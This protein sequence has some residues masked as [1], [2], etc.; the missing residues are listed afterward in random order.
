MARCESLAEKIGTVRPSLRIAL[1]ASFAAL[2]IVL[3]LISPFIPAIGIPDIKIRLEASFASLFGFVLGPYLGASAALIGTLGAT[4]LHGATLFDLIFVFNPA[5]NALIVGLVLRKQWKV[6]FAMFALTI[7]AFWLTP[8]CAPLSEYWSVGLGANF[9]KILALLLIIP[10]SRIMQQGRKD[11]SRLGV[12][13]SLSFLLIFLLSFVGNQ[14]DAALGNNIF[15]LP[16]VYEGLFSLSVDA[17]RWLF[18]VSPF[19][20]PVIRIIQAFVAASLG[21]PLMRALRKMKIYGA[22][23]F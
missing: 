6:A 21:L 17:T 15:A 11:E 18:T 2:Y 16:A 5:L 3:S 22:A 23:G 12:S 8:I 20:Y 9:D 7:L 13:T 4:M 14:A 19:I 1:V 10:I